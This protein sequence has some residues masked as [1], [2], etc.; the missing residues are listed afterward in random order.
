MSVSDRGGSDLPPSFSQCSQA[1]P[2]GELKTKEMKIMSNEKEPKMEN[3]IQCV[4]Y[5]GDMNNYL[6]CPI[7]GFEF[8][9]PISV[10]VTREKE[11]TEITGKGIFIRDAENLGRGVIIE[12]EYVCENGHHGIIR[13]RFYKG[14]TY[15]GH[16][17]LP[18]LKH[19]EWE[20]IW[21]N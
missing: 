3:V 9:H 11:T 18:E 5:G 12:L 19:D 15:V 14:S 21:R 13:L 17:E 4:G 6:V 2:E 16:V 8:V 20:T 10:R 7:C 1:S